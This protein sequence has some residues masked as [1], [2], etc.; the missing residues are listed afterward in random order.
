MNLFPPF[1]FI[2]AALAMSAAMAAPGVMLR[3]DLLR[4]AAT[5]GAPSLGKLAKGSDVV[6]ETRRAGWVRVKAN[7]RS[8]WVRILSVRESRAAAAPDV[9]GAVRLADRKSDPDRVVAVAGIRGLDAGSLNEAS[10]KLASFNAGELVWLE[11]YRARRPDAESQ[12]R[13]SQLRRR[14]LAYLPAPE[15]A[16][17]KEHV[18]P[19]GE[20]GWP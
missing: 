19:W 1:L 2:F 18:S 14:D 5:A 15:V 6:I 16:R 7:G 10:L 3:E 13:L 8:G 20:G 4:A 17:G 11:R 9:S 12:A